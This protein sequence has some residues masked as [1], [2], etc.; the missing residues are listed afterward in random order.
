MVKICQW[1]IWYADFPYEECEGSSKRPVIVINIEGEK[2]VVLL[3]VK[4][5][6]HEPRSADQFDTPIAKWKEAGLNYPSV[7]RISKTIKLTEDKF[8]WKIGDLQPEDVIA[9]SSRYIDYIFES[10]ANKANAVNE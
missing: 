10:Q 8:M 9:I 2:P 4:I 1:E 6:K 7:A 5:T 3:S